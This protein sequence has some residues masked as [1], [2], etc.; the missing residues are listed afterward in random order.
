M[1]KEQKVVK[2][3]DFLEEFKEALVERV[4]GE[5][6]PLYQPDVD[7]EKTAVVLSQLK[8]R[9]FVAQADTINAVANILQQER[10]AVIVGEMGV[11]KTIL[12][13]ATAH[14]IGAKKVLVCCPPHLVKKWE[15][16]IRL[17]IHDVDVMHLRDIRDMYGLEKLISLK[18]QGSLFCVVSRERAKLGFSWKAS[19]VAKRLKDPETTIGVKPKKRAPL[20]ERVA[21]IPTLEILTCPRC[22]CHLKDDEGIYLSW[23]DLKR[24][25]TKCQKCGESLWMADKDGVYR[26]PIAEYVKRFLPR[27]FDL[28]IIDETHEA[29]AKATAQGIA[30]GMMASAS[31]KS[32]A[33]IGTLFGGYSRTL[34]YILHRFTQGFHK[35]FHYDD[36]WKWV[37]QYGIVEKVTR[38]RLDADYDDNVMS[39]GKKR[40]VTIRERPGISPVVLPKYLL[41]RCVFIRLADI[42]LALPKYDEFIVSLNME[43]E[44]KEGYEEFQSDLVAALRECLRRGDKSMLSKYLQGL[45]CYP[46]QPWTGEVVRNKHGEIV[47]IARKCPEERTY[48]KEQELVNIIKEEKARGRRVLVYCSHTDTRDMTERLRKLLEENRIR[49]EVLHANVEPEKREA[50]IASRVRGLDAL[51]TN[52]KLVQTGL[53]LI[54]FQTLVFHE[55]EYSVYVLRQASRR[56]WRIGQEKP[57][58]VFYLIYGGTIQEKGLKLI[59]QKFKTSL[60][61]EGELMDDGLSTYNTDGGDLY[62]DL[63]RSIVSGVDDVK[64]SLDAIWAEVRAK[65]M[66]LLE[67]TVVEEPFVEERLV[68]TVSKRGEVQTHVVNTLYDDLWMKLMEIRAKK[69][70]RPKKVDERQLFLFQ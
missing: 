16:E 39:R 2:L 65:E 57:V 56:S 35:D 15:R 14:V 50:W 3:S 68:E 23:V 62:Y 32:V 61:I 24:K 17:T 9:P 18:V 28:F 13:I 60:A 37:N 48:P 41:E 30:A 10:N 20:R 47:A 67:A 1:S 46:E 55:I 38:T 31:K 7:R 36:E 42:A 33:L 29:K 53:D 52:P 49:T 22:G 27:F 34:F 51:I 12:G 66:E 19:A 63:A 44:Q 8:R 45:L 21:C 25:K 59:A 5:Y 43:P 70:S 69:M 4:V 6:P 64:G 54:D 11:G 26:Y 58:K 40:S